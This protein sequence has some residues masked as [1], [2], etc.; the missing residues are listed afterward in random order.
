VS[1]WRGEAEATKR[2]QAIAR[3]EK[4][5]RMFR[6]QISSD[7]MRHYWPADWKPPSGPRAPH[8]LSRDQFW[9]N[10]AGAAKNLNR[11]R[12]D[13]GLPPT[14]LPEIPPDLSYLCEEP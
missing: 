5:E 8:A 2:D 11:R 3:L 4:A 10:V 7:S 13:L 9:R 12:A 14:P 1:R 6:Y